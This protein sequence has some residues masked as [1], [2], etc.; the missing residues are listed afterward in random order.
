MLQRFPVLLLFISIYL[1]YT[2]TALEHMPSWKMPSSFLSSISPFSWPSPSS[3]LLI[4]QD[5]AQMPR[6]LP[7]RSWNDPLPCAFQH[8]YSICAVFES[9]SVN[10][11]C[12]RVRSQRECQALENRDFVLSYSRVLSTLHDAW[13]FDWHLGKVCWVTNNLHCKQTT[14]GANIC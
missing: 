4:L 7:T 11:T 8:G 14:T 2:L 10:R 12:V 6:C 5:L 1:P 13:H 9:A 3:S